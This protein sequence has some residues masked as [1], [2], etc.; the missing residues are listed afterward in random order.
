M[1]SGLFYAIENLASIPTSHDAGEPVP[2]A[3]FCRL[4]SIERM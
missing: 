1:K 2:A 3:A 4:G